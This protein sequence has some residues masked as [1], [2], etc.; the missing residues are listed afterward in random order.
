MFIKCAI[1]AWKR[2]SKTMKLQYSSWVQYTR[3]W[4]KSVWCKTV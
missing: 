4:Y 2:F 3:C 1:Q